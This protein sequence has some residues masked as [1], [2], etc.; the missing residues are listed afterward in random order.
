MSSEV[1]DMQLCVSVCV[2]SMTCQSNST[3]LSAGT[4][5]S[6]E[7]PC[8]THK[9]SHSNSPHTL[10]FH[11]L[12]YISHKSPLT[13]T[14]TFLWHALPLLFHL[15]CSCSIHQMADPSAPPLFPSLS[16]SVALSL[17]NAPCFM[18]GQTKFCIYRTPPVHSDAGC[19]HGWLAP[20]LQWLRVFVRICF[21]AS[22][23]WWLLKL[24]VPRVCVC[25]HICLGSQIMA[26]C[27]QH[28]RHLLQYIRIWRGVCL[29]ID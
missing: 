2:F 16:T 10:L 5:V 14:H 29:I 21:I 6:A 23:C 26:V 22:F 18:L 27:V 7:Q 9:L 11:S 25:V 24:V 8:C 13:Y 28:I 19:S 15:S 20:L 4:W 12:I 3:G 17:P 1:K